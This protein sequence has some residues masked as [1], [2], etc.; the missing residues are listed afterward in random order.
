MLTFGGINF[1]IFPSAV[2][3]LPILFTTTGFVS[4]VE[5]GIE[6]LIGFVK[7]GELMPTLGTV[8]VLEVV[9]TTFG[10][11]VA[12]DAAVSRSFPPP[13]MSDVEIYN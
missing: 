2:V 1:I 5:P 12:N 4:V 13:I 11:L 10:F 9:G 3:T 8:I 7:Y 6:I